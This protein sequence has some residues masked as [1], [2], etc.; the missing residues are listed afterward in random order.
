MAVCFRRA[1]F[2]LYQ[3]PKSNGGMIRTPLTARGL[4]RVDL[5]EI[6]THPPVVIE[7]WHELQGTRVFPFPNRRA[8]G[9]S[10]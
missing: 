10:N 2:I 6:V 4:D 3:F 7:K 5:E 1:N 9:S 8:W